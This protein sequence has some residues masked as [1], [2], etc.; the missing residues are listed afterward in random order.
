MKTIALIATVAALAIAGCGGNGNGY[1]GGSSSSGASATSDSGATQISTAKNAKVGQT[2]LVNGDGMTIYAL[3]AEKN[4]KFICTD[5]KCLALWK[6]VSGASKGDVGSLAMVNRPDGKQ[7]ATYKGEPLYTFTGDKKKGDANGEGFKDV[8][9]WH[10]VAISG[11]PASSGS[12]GSGS[13]GSGTGGS[14]SGGAG[15]YGY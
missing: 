1:G 3:S 13:G 6:P 5:S 14:G 12:G 11:Q 15:G 10:A 7:Q 8:G 2:V 4:G 9:T